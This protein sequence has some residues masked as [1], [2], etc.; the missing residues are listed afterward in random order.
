MYIRTAPQ[1]A[2]IIR[3]VQ[4]CNS[5]SQLHMLVASN[6]R[7]AVKGSAKLG[8]ASIVFMTDMNLQMP[9]KFAFIANTLSPTQPINIVSYHFSITVHLLSEHD[10]IIITSRTKLYLIPPYDIFN[11]FCWVSTSVKWVAHFTILH[12][13]YRQG[14]KLG[15]LACFLN[16]IFLFKNLLLLIHAKLS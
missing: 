14:E 6:N 15:C 8:D 11:E 5:I 12:L 3:R 10:I 16:V 9:F 1:T 2:F 13:A 4:S 7:K